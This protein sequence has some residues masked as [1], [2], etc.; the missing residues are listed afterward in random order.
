METLLCQ[1]VCKDTSFFNITKVF[2][3]L[4]HS[5]INRKPSSFFLK[6]KVRA[7]LETLFPLSVAHGAFSNRGYWGIVLNVSRQPT[8]KTDN[9][10]NRGV[11]LLYLPR[12]FPHQMTIGLIATNQEMY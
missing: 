6:R 2:S 10:N 9:H 1:K 5:V 7:F 8:K 11:S 3:I 12:H 4:K